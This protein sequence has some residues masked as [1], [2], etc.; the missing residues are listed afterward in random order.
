[1][2]QLKLTLTR[3]TALEFLK[4]LDEINK[5]FNNYFDPIDKDGL[6]KNIVLSNLLQLQ[7]NLINVIF[8][9]GMNNK[10][11]FKLAVSN[12][13]RLSL[14]KIITYYPLHYSL[15]GIEFEIING[16][17]KNNIS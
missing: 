9:N 15:A 2:K 1:M 13:E 6:Y 14:F 5:H 16:L 17:E 7:K 10:S 3:S 11:N 12:A 8:R 4:Y